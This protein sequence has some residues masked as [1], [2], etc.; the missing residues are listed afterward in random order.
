MSSLLPTR[1]R[2]VA[3]QRATTTIPIVMAT[4]LDPVAARLVQS[5]R[6]PGGNIT[7][8]YSL[9]QELGAKRIELLSELIPGISRVAILWDADA[10]GPKQRFQDYLA[11]AKSRKLDVL[12]LEVKAQTADFEALI[13]TAVS[14]RAQALLVVS[15]P[16]MATVMKRVAALAAE[17]KL[18]TMGEGRGLFNSGGFVSYDQ[19][20]DE[21]PKM[22]ANIV[23][24]VLKGAKP[25]NLPIAQPTRFELIVNLKTAQ[26]LGTKIPP[27]IMVRA[28]RVIQ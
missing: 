10:P 2:L 23:A 7:G 13:R 17:H 19:D 8:I 12:S 15:N 6:Q 26:A 9:Q 28:T 22:L 25:A 20:V 18:P 27:E 14:S 21:Q 3:A 24:R 5:F 16:Y 1:S 4:S 11:A